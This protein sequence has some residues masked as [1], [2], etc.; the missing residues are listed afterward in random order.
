MEY[1]DGCSTTIRYVA[2]KVGLYVLE[3]ILL[4]GYNLQM[5]GLAYDSVSLLSFM[6]IGYFGKIQSLLR[7][8]LCY[9][10]SVWTDF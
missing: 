4:Q 5:G 3:M 1:S 9:K 8:N 6:S 7:D 2:R 10:T